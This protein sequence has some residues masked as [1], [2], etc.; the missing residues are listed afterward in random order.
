MNEK[1][2]ESYKALAD[3]YTNSRNRE[4][5][6]IEIYKENNIIEIND[7]FIDFGIIKEPVKSFR[8]DLPWSEDHFIERING[9][10][11]NPGN[12]YKNWPYYKRSNSEKLFRSSGVFSHN[13]MERYWCSNLKG[14]RYNYGDLNSI[15]ERL[16]QNPYTRQA[17]LSVW[18]PEDQSNNSVRVP[19]TLGYWFNNNNGNLNITYHIR[20]CDA[21]RHFRN[22]L[23]MTYRLLEYV[24][25][26]TNQ[27]P[28]KF[29]IWIGSFHC[30]KSDLYTLKKYVRD[31]N[32]L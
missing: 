31:S 21:I 16:K 24:A 11:I 1:V 10:P 13:Y 8:P 9:Q 4:W 29:K 7:L 17:Y 26:Q 12:E 14:L 3:S 6:S 20:S 15:I 25:K 27:K 2:M 30:F 19:C 5:Q 23:Y 28:G 18:H 22:D 32:N